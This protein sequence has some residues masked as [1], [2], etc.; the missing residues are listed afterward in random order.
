MLSVLFVKGS[1][2]VAGDVTINDGVRLSSIWVH[3][4]VIDL[5]H[6]LVYI[7]H[8]IALNFYS[9]YHMKEQLCL[10]NITQVA[11]VVNNRSMNELPELNGLLSYRTDDRE[12]YLKK[13]SQWEALATQKYVGYI[14]FIS[15]FNIKI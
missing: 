7:L 2:S 1:C 6:E 11:V 9:K 12:L 15:T 8:C 10:I 5:F 14:L 13:N 3:R 4:I